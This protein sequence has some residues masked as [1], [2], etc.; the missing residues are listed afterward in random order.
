SE[1]GPKPDCSDCV[2]AAAWAPNNS[3]AGTSG[4]LTV[5]VTRVTNNVSL[6]LTSGVTLPSTGTGPFPFVIGISLVPGNGPFTGSLPSS[7]F[8][9]DKIATVEYLHDQVAQYA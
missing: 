5:T 3:T 4:T 1:I 8:P 6:V 9:S 2:I 7:M